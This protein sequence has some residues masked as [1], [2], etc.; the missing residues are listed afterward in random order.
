MIL[1]RCRIVRGVRLLRTQN[2]DTF[3]CSGCK[4]ND[5]KRGGEYFCKFINKNQSLYINKLCEGFKK[6][7]W[8][9]YRMFSRFKYFPK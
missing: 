7:Y 9:N 5:D 1:K 4:Y 2:S 6:Y 3:Y 8:S